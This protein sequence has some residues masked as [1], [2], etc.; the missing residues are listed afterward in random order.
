MSS[1]S[2][3]AARHSKDSMRKHDVIGS[4][5]WRGMFKFGPLAMFR[6]TPSCDPP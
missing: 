6:V 2:V 3:M 5:E 1:T 4:T